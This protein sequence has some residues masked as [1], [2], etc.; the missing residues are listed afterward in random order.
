MA[1]YEQP[2]LLEAAKRFAAPLPGISRP[3]LQGYAVL[4]AEYLKASGLYIQLETRFG[5]DLRG[6]ICY[7]HG[8]SW[9]F[10]DFPCIFH[11]F[12]LKKP[13]CATASRLPVSQESCGAHRGCGQRTTLW[14]LQRPPLRPVSTLMRLRKGTEADAALLQL[15]PFLLTNAKE[16][17]VLSLAPDCGEAVMAVRRDRLGAAWGVQV[18]VPRCAR[19]SGLDVESS[20]FKSL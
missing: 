12:L 1:R 13:W 20:I 18:G 4:L 14:G 5:T 7:F 15:L 2:Y 6:I 19:A 11:V 3:E 9:Y 16:G 10:T 8:F 17:L